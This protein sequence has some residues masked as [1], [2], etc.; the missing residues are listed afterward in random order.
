MV[1][2]CDGNDEYERWGMM[3]ENMENTHYWFIILF[4]ISSI[5]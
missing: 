2:M 4:I 5:S 1:D 3:D